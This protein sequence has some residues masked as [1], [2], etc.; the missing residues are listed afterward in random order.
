MEVRPLDVV[1]TAIW[2]V[3]LPT[4]FVGWLGFTR[5]VGR[6]AA[7][8]DVLTALIWC[9]AMSFGGLWLSVPRWFI[10]LPLLGVVP[11][12]RRRFRRVRRAGAHPGAPTRS[13][14]AAAGSAGFRGLGL[15]M[16][17]GLLGAALLGRAD[18]PG[19]PFAL[20][21]PLPEGRWLVANGG[22]TRAVNPHLRTLEGSTAAE[23]RGQSH[24]V[25][26]VAAGTWG[27]RAR[28]TVA[29]DLEDYEIFGVPVLAPCSG[30]VVVSHDGELERPDASAPWQSRPGNHVILDCGGA[31]VL[32]AHFT[33]GSIVVEVGDE[34]RVGDPVARVGNTGA[35]GEPHL[36]VHAQAPGTRG[37]PFGATP[38]PITIDGRFLVR[39]DRLRSQSAHPGA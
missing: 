7:L 37:V 18:P 10:L 3:G 24:A 25:D 2:N 9:L 1:Q 4:V 21:S 30:R 33:T 19:E 17:A 29:P 32:L 26:L 20:A 27:S 5:S 8:L 31:W 34:V 38:L 39:N 6:P 13:R 16:G 22:S 15:L 36:H 12:A 28:P 35:S 23:W 14:L 11:A